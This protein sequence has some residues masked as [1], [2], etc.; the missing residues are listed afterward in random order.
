MVNVV[1]FCLYGSHSTYILGMKE[2]I[3]LAKEFYPGWEV[4]IYYNKTVPEKYIKEYEELGAVCHLC[5][6]VGKN[7]MNWEGMFWRWMP[8]DDPEV[9]V[10][11]SR[12]ADSRLS[13]RE[14]KIVNA[15]MNSG[16]T[17]HCI[18]DHRCHYNCIMGGMF[19][20]NNKL[21]HKKYKF[22]KV[23]DIIKEN[24]QY[25]RE[26]PYNVDQI[27]LN[28]KL[29]SLLKNDSMSHISNGGRRVFK[30]DI[31][32]SPV[33]DFIG[34]Q[35][36]L[37]DT[38]SEKVNLTSIDMV[39]KTFRIKN[40]YTN[41]CF[42]I[43]KEKVKL[44]VVSDSDSQ[45][46]KMNDKHKIINIS[47][48]KFLDFDNKK[49]LTIS[50]NDKN[51]W[52][53][54]EGGFI[55]NNQTKMAIDFK[56]GFTD[57]RLEPWLY[58]FNYSEAQQWEFL[59]D[60]S[61]RVFRIKNVYNNKCF[62]VEN[63]KV[64]LALIDNNNAEQ[65]WKLDKENKI[66]H[67][68]T[69]KIINIGKNRDLVVTENSEH[70]WKI[71]DGGFIINSKNNQS[72][73]I[74]GG[75]IDKRNEVWLYNLN[76]SEAQQ[77]ELVD[78]N[79][80]NIITENKTEKNLLSHRLD[81]YFDQIYIIH[82]DC[83]L[84]RKKSIIEQVNQ[85]G[86]K[87]IT[88]IDAINKNDIDVEKMKENDTIAYPGNN[89][90]KNAKIC[91]CG[92]KGH[93]NYKFP[94]R[95][96]CMQGHY[97]VWKDIIKNNHKKCL[98]LEDDFILTKDLHERFDKIYKN[99]PPDWELI[100]FSNSRWI[101]QTLDTQHPKF[102]TSGKD[103]NDS[104]CTTP[105]GQK[106]TGCYSVTNDCA[107]KMHDN[108]MPLRGGSDGYIGMCIDTLK[109]VNHAYI[110]KQD[111][112][113]N[114][115]LRPW[116]SGNNFS[117]FQ[118]N[119]RSFTSCVERDINLNIDDNEKIILNNELRKLVNKYE[120]TNINALYEK[121]Q[122]NLYFDQIYI[123]HLDCFTERK[124]KMIEQ[125]KKFNLKN[126]TIID[127]I[128]K[129]D[130]D[131]EKCKKNNIIAYLG[132]EY[133]KNDSECSCNGR[134]HKIGEFSGRIACSYGHYLVWN[135]MIKNNYDKCLILEDDFRLNSDFH[136]K[137]NILYQNLPKQWDVILFENRWII[138]K[139]IKP[140]YKNIH[141]KDIVDDNNYFFK[142]PYGCQDAG[143]YAITSNTAKILKKKYLPIRGGADG[144]MGMCLDRYYLLN[145]FYISKIDLSVNGSIDTYKGYTEN[146]HSITSVD[147]MDP[148]LNLELKQLVNKYEKTDINSLYGLSHN[149]KTSQ[150]DIKNILVLNHKFHH[151]NK[152]GL[153]M[154]C[155]YLDYNLIYGS[156]KDIPKADVVYCPSRPFN[157]SKYPNKR[158][159]FGPHL[160]I[161]PDNKLHSIQNKNN[162]VYIQPSPWVRD[163]WIEKG[164]DKYL[165]VVHF[166]Y[167][168]DVNKFKPMNDTTK[169][170]V[171]VMFKY[172][173]NTELTFIENQ[174]KSKNES[175]R[176]FKYGSYQEE[177]YVKYLQTCKYGIWIG[178][179]ESQGFG[180]QEALS[181]DIP[182]LVWS[183]TNLNQQENW[184]GAPDIKAT[185]VAYW[186][187][188][189]GEYFNK[190]DEFEKTY[191]TFLQNL[192]NYKPR[193]FVLNTVSV[194]QC[195][196]NFKKVFLNNNCT[197][198]IEY[199]D[200]INK[201]LEY[202]DS[203]YKEIPT[204]LLSKYTLE[205]EIPIL[206][207]FDDGRKA[208]L[209][210]NWDDA[211]IGKYKN[212]FLNENIKK[213]IS[214]W[215]HEP[216][217]YDKAS[218]N[219]LMSVEK[220][221]IHN[222][223]VA[224]IGTTIPWIEAILLNNNNNITTVEYNIPKCTVDNLTCI[225]YDDFVKSN[226]TYDCIF[227]YSSTEHCGLGRYGDP[228]D[229]DGDLTAMKHIYDKLGKDSY[230]FWGGPVGKDTL[231]WN[232][233]RIYGPL[234]LSMLFEGF[235]DV[236][237]MGFN[238]Q[239]LFNSPINKIAKQPLVVLK[240]NKQ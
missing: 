78:D 219:V 17:L 5:E 18:R 114:G 16:K 213:Q 187:K 166:P 182:L 67:V 142:T 218:Y 238:K 164:A 210:Q 44:K 151:K 155:D 81:D 228:L 116:I 26:R 209:N 64:K 207:W 203:P 235:D 52:N 220:Y 100:Y 121:N 93:E 70:T 167:P 39:N 202:L 125:I 191:Q 163:L 38:T 133:C 139:E 41:H 197:D 6:N 120:K 72:I 84:D 199:P 185:T 168:V 14:A 233:H 126:I 20:I 217:P 10:W 176:I 231:V 8:L 188:I 76:Y 19:G 85:F 12:D 130:I 106:D 129:H 103:Y 58:K 224:I 47:T 179:H 124:K 25:Y 34:K 148:S 30:E 159:V 237:W 136:D 57:K 102:G 53:I 108:A 1:S 205:G 42:D 22:K 7:K 170:N 140:R 3:K 94:G 111:L 158:F 154:I 173:K 59:E 86:L 83:L 48:G 137:F 169:N 189:C 227:S 105:F 96:A 150:K 135:D 13:G 196:E 32:I 21:F 11:V 23:K 87:N 109:I 54:Q 115:T 63:D 31:E 88:I 193:E 147:N 144:F 201:K 221:D 37:N 239:N 186:D 190:Q 145:D 43:E 180:L 4:Y 61:K 92:G 29:W 225:H 138:N 9:E 141:K 143:C 240:K 91:T 162:S 184:R 101:K 82:L 174:L 95:I 112:S 200:D 128:N 65:L 118:H 104:F 160:S 66:V 214:L 204:E 62:V 60:N 177:D 74:K 156:E 211:Y 77:W 36:R 127:G 15:F 49:D 69:N 71:E 153:E 122:V 236:E 230:L 35:Y 2:N 98:V 192:N 123:I 73:D 181:C 215:K 28:D 56:G 146:T 80:T 223:K 46:W 171:L 89:F 68:A 198:V 195:A 234:R 226:T 208:L 229:P 172:R 110:C 161:F 90:C 157:A 178:T 79:S 97:L 222:K 40:L 216:Y 27:F 134:G 232:V 212:L 24:Y 119:G 194:K 152:K 117:P 33:G 132:N 165:P 175:Y 55:V 99:F 50:L 149:N 51:T 45:L 206:D 131:I 75:L 107:K 183:V 113:F